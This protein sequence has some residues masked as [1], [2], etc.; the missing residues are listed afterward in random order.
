MGMELEEEGGEVYK[1][2]TKTKQR[3]KQQQ[4]NTPTPQNNNNNNNNNNNTSRRNGARGCMMMQ[5]LKLLIPYKRRQR[6]VLGWYQRRGVW[7]CQSGN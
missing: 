4:I 3:N 6:G 5:G 2:K 1:R 7:A